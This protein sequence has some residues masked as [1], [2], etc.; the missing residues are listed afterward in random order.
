MNMNA[1]N[2]CYWLQGFF[3]LTN[4]VNLTEEQVKIVKEHLQLVF[5]K[6]TEEK[7]DEK[8]AKSDESTLNEKNTK[9]NTVIKSEKNI[10]NQNNNFSRYKTTTR[11]C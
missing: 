7:I 11:Y 2:F 1:D 8:T 9:E 5:V 3:E 10:I 6:V 4:S